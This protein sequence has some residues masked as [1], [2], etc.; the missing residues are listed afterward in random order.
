MRSN[1]DTTFKKVLFLSYY[2][3]P[4]GGSAVQRC[5]KFTK[6]LPEYG[7]QPHVLTARVQDVFVRD[8]SLM[9]Q[10]PEQVKVVRTPAPDLYGIYSGR[11]KRAVDL[12][13]ISTSKAGKGSWIQRL[14]LWVRRTLFIPDARI[15]WLPFAFFRG[16]EII[17][18]EKIDIIFAT[19]PPFT[20]ALIGNLLST[21]TGIPWISDY[22]DPWTQAYFYFKRPLI[23][24]W[25]ENTWERKCLF[26]AKKV[27]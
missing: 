13:A 15:G 7:W 27:I 24:Q 22:R 16:L 3:P 8:D 12:G 14:A 25:I 10:I 20:T 2:F 17:R 21:F 11:G 26:H 4:A 5:L 18:K 9:H 23:S 6:Y 1:S 19:S